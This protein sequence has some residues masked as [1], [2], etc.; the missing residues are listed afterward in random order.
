MKKKQIKPTARPTILPTVKPTTKPTVAPTIEP[1]TRPTVVPTIKPTVEPTTEPVVVPT[2]VPTTDP[3]PSQDSKNE[4]EVL[5]LKQI[6]KEQ[7]ELGATVSEDLDSK[8]YIWDEGRLIALYWDCKN[9]EKPLPSD[10]D[11]RSVD[12]DFYSSPLYKR[13]LSCQN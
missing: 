9:D 5:A 7:K 10:A 11:R 2:A 4:E 13:Y 3:T 8:E 1:T 6:I 12:A